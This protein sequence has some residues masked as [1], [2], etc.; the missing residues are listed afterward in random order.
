MQEVTFF[1]PMTQKRDAS[2]LVGEWRFFKRR[3]EPVLQCNR[4]GFAE[5]IGYNVT[6]GNAFISQQDFAAILQRWKQEKATGIMQE[7]N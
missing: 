4:A 7:D 3:S 6:Y 5:C 1:V 2:I